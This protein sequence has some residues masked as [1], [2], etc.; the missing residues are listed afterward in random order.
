MRTSLNMAGQLMRDALDERNSADTRANAAY[1]AGYFYVLASTRW[2]MKAPYECIAPL[3]K[4]T[5]H[6]RLSDAEMD[7][8]SAFAEA[9][10]DHVAKVK[11]LPSLLQWAHQM[12]RLAEV[13][14]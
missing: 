7:P 5:T 1:D 3:K 12:K 11:L 6:F 9:M 4:M 14:K 13:P 2:S 10:H 8:A